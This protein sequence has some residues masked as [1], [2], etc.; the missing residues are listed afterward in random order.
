VAFLAGPPIL[1]FIGQTEGLRTAILPVLVLV[2]I[3]ACV[4]PRAA[5]AEPGGSTAEVG[6]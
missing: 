4:A 6:A 3:A 5:R 1:G 2:A